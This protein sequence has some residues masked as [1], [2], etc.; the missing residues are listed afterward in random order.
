MSEPTNADA[1]DTVL[2]QLVGAFDEVGRQLVGTRPEKVLS[3]LARIAVEQIGGAEAASITRFTLPRS[4]A[5]VAATHQRARQADAIQYALGAGP[6]L[7]AIT[8]DTVHAPIELSRDRRWPEFAVR[9]ASEC[10]VASMLSYRLGVQ[11]AVASLNVYSGG[12]DVFDERGVELG[13]LLAT[14]GSVA[15][16][17][18][19]EKDRSDHLQYALESRTDIGVAIGVVMALHKLTREEA[20]TVLRILS[21][22]G[23]RKLR[24][25]ALEV[26]ETGTLP[27]PRGFPSPLRTS[28]CRRPTRN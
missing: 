28:P 1:A 4:F 7:D 12:V 16:L 3:A 2:R 22:R 20:F 17:A 13:L 23:N 26:A 14:H 15:L 18:A 25:L 8:A 21:Q 5:T 24:E 27:Q 11:E 9:A 6:C 10:G 19:S